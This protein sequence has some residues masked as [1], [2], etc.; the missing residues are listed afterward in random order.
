MSRKSKKYH[1][2]NNPL[3]AVLFGVA[4]WKVLTGVAVFASLGVLYKTSS[5]ATV[6]DTSVLDKLA[7]RQDYAAL[8]N[9]YGTLVEKAKEEHV[10]NTFEELKA[11]TDT[12][13]AALTLPPESVTAAYLQASVFLMESYLLSGN[14]LLYDRSLEIFNKSTSQSM[15]PQKAPQLISEI[16]QES[17]KLIIGTPFKDQRS[18]FHIAYALASVLDEFGIKNTQLDQ[19]HIDQIVA[20]EALMAAC[21]NQKPLNAIIAALS[22]Q[23]KPICITDQEWLYIRVG[24]YGA[25]LAI[26]GGILSTPLRVAS[27][28]GETL[29]TIVGTAKDLNTVPKKKN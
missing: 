3:P 12:S 15:N 21:N 10:Y 13:V 25:V 14:K 22:F 29:G 11:A 28:L 8:A 20:E 27:S 9:L 24:T 5:L 26:V 1:T 17:Y 23:K 6:V 2:R 7:S 4:T 18:K 19:Q 16:L